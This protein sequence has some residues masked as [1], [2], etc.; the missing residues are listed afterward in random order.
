MN[1][2][3]FYYRTKFFNDILHE[4]FNVES[5]YRTEL[6][7]LNL[8]ICRKIEDFK[9]KINQKKTDNLRQSLPI[10]K[11]F[12]RAVTDSTLKTCKTN[13]IIDID[14]ED[15]TKFDKLISGS[16][17][18]LLKFYKTKHN[19]ISKEVS[20]L[21]I[22]I[23]QFS[24]SFK[25]YERYLDTNIVEKCKKDFE[26]HFSQLMEAKKKY[27]EKMNNLELYFHE[28]EEKKEK[29]VEIKTKEK[30]RNIIN[31]DN[32]KIDELIELR[33]Q[34]KKSLAE[35]TSEQK[36][37]ISQMNEMANDMQDFNLTENNLL[38]DIFTIFEKNLEALLQEIKNVSLLYQKNRKSIQD[39]NKEL[40]NNLIFDKRLYIGYKFEEYEPMFTDINNRINLSVIQKMNKLLGFE[41]D[42]IKT[43]KPNN[44][45]LADTI[46]YNSIDLDEN[47]LFILLMDKFIQGENA[48]DEKERVLLKNL[49]NQDKYLKEFVNKINNMRIERNKFYK[50]EKFEGLAD[51]FNEIISKISFSNDKNHELVKCIM[52]LSETYFYKEGNDKIYLNKLINF[53]KEINDI[54]FWIKYLEE[55]IEYESKKYK[56]QN[57]SRYEYIVLLSNT[58]HL[59]EFSF[60]KEKINE[61]IEFFKNKYKLTYEEIKVIKEQLH[62]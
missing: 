49:F 20:N 27:F 48:L 57:N 42:K 12:K 38:F 2:N 41:F 60:E 28:E 52:I 14:K 6:N 16:L 45:N 37:F 54:K 56:N 51:C 61:L 25:K 53:P 3:N 32:Q 18:N 4:I 33:K 36:S 24:S 9:K 39:C 46:I 8:K 43:N 29:K 7:L 10:K 35:M 34:Y 13:D 62:L 21:G 5:N 40:G 30:N 31:D 22:A 59:R 58:A 19:L 50:K 55:E 15:N 26:K 44:D 47:V 11:V 23:Y 17:Q 1:T